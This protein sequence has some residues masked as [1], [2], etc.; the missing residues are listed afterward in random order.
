MKV[1]RHQIDSFLK[2]RTIAIAGE[3]MNDKKFGKTIFGHLANNGYHVIPIKYNT[4]RFNGYKCYPSVND[5]PSDVES[6]LIA[7][8]KEQTDH[9]LKSAINR[10]IKNIWIQQHANTKQTISI[11]KARQHDIIHSQCICLFASRT[12]GIHKLHKGILQLFN[13][14]AN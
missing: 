11:A 3:S 5:L 2:A 7:T 1:T 13:L 4:N 10:G 6:L 8:P 9:I 12:K 14:I